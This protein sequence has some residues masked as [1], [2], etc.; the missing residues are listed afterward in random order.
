MWTGAAAAAPRPCVEN[1]NGVWSDQEELNR[2]GA[3]KVCS[4][5][6]TRCEQCWEFFSMNATG[7]CVPCKST[8]TPTG[9]VLTCISCKGD[10]P[11]LCYNCGGRSLV[12]E[13]EDDVTGYYANESGK[14][15]QCPTPGCTECQ[16][17]TGVCL[18]CEPGY[19]YVDGSCQKCKQGDRIEQT[20]V[21][22]DVTQVTSI[23]PL[24]E[25]LCREGVDKCTQCSELGFGPDPTTA[26]CVACT[27]PNCADCGNSAAACTKCGPGFVLEGATTTCVPCK[28]QHCSWC[29]V[30]SQTGQEEC[31][32]CMDG[33]TSSVV[34]ADPITA[35]V[36]GN[37]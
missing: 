23:S 35:C 32:S 3:C 25:N 15:I 29:R 13:E 7:D 14:C 21:E 34:N 10:D 18:Q 17:I 24:C 4:A 8:K 19:G 33:Y 22:G 5:D 37:T 36:P 20:D 27:T 1:I 11:S 2:V 6:G 16:N 28:V 26:R 12:R 9:T 31:E 30:S